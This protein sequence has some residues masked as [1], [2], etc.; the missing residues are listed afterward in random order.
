MQTYRERSLTNNILARLQQ[1]PA[2][3]LLGPRQCGK[4]TLAKYLLS[5][6]ANGLYLDL[7]KSSDL[8]Q[9]SIES[10]VG[11]IAYLEMTPF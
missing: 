10:L 11:R 8:I 6:M 3:A 7:E 2:V 1:M 9:Q 5:P 4:S